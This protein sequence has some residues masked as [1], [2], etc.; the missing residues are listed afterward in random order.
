MIYINDLGKISGYVTY[1]IAT[2]RRDEL[3]A[4]LQRIRTCCWQRVE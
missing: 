4:R 2:G 3:Y 1:Y